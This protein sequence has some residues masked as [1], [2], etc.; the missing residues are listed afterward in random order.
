[1]AG[2]EGLHG[3]SMTSF[4]L[5]SLGVILEIRLK[6]EDLVLVSIELVELMIPN[7]F[8]V[9]LCN[10]L[11]VSLNSFKAKCSM[12]FRLKSI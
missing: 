8:F 1:M 5:Y 7:P 6:M 3:Y 11:E 2:H 4:F 10:P 12:S 9:I